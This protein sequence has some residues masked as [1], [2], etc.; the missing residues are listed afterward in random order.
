MK[1]GKVASVLGGEGK[2]GRGAYRWRR[3]GSV[4]QRDRQDGELQADKSLMKVGGDGS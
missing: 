1:Q 2:E 4:G 3:E